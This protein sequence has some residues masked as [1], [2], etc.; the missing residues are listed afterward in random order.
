MLNEQVLISFYGDDFSGTTATAEAL[1]QSGL[2]TVIFTE[3]PSPAYLKCHFPL[4]RAMGISGTARTLPTAVIKQSL[5]SVFLAMKSYQSPIY[6]YKV[7]STFDSSAQVGNIGKAIELGIEIFSPDFVPVL[8]AAPKL[9]RYTIFGNHFA[10]MGSG[11]IFRLDRHPSI[12]KHPVTPMKEA[13]LRCH[14]AKQTD[15][16]SGLINIL[17]IEA[18]SEK[19]NAQIDELLATGMEVIFF[20]CLSVNNLNTICETVVA[21]IH[22]KKPGFFVGSHEMG[23]GLVNALIKKGPLLDRIF[24]EPNLEGVSHKGP[25]LVLSGSCA[26]VTAD[27]IKWAKTH[28][29]I[30]LAVSVE[31]L[32]DSAKKEN[33]R[34]KMVRA[35]CN[36]LSSGRSVIVHTAIGPQDERIMAMK[37]KAGQL[38]LSETEASRILGDEL[39]DIAQKI[40]HRSSV[41]RLVVAGGDTSGR[42]QKYLQ[43]KALQVAKSIGLGAPLCYVFSQRKKINGLE[44]AFKGGQIGDPDYFV[45]AQ[46]AHTAE[47]EKVALGT[48]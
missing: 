21:R 4:V 30:D 26:I 1:M 6:V 13:D 36:E 32:F 15:M 45:Q 43:I 2:P 41:K 38:S 34:E 25:I 7:C 12:S 37:K 39:G 42:I 28:G 16:K 29:F 11:D 5:T 31:N 23:Y 8:P 9:G 48:I 44:V 10:A 3:P 35:A 17:D 27:Q 20:D 33:E 14:L 46:S 40:L 47:F 19:I 24:S 22:R 18:G